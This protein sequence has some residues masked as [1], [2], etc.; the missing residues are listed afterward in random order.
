MNFFV[1]KCFFVSIAS[2]MVAMVPSVTMAQMQK[3]QVRT[4]ERPNKKSQGLGGVVITVREAPNS[5]LSSAEGSF[6]FSLPGKKEGDSYTVLGVQKTNYALVD[7]G[8]RG[9]KYGYSSKTPL[10][11]VMVSH[12]QLE[13]EKHRIEDNNSARALREY[14]KQKDELEALRREKRIS[15]E[16]YK[17]RQRRLGDDFEKLMSLIDKMAEMYALFDYKNISDLNRQIAEA[18]ENAEL[19]KAES[20]I[21]TKGDFDQREKQIKETMEMGRQ[22]IAMGE[23]TM[24]E[25]I[26]QMNDLAEDYY[27]QHTI[28]V[29]NYKFDEAATYLE[30]RAALDSTNAGWQLEVA[31]FVG[32]YLSDYER[33]EKCATKA[34]QTAL[35]KD[36]ANTKMVAYCLN[37]MGNN[38]CD[39]GKFDKALDYYWRSLE[40]RR[41]VFGEQSEETAK[42][43]SNMAVVYK[44]KDMLDSARVYYEKALQI[45]QASTDDDCGTIALSYIDMGQLE[46]TVGDAKKALEYYQMALPLISECKGE[47]SDAMAELCNALAAAN[48]DVDSLNAALGWYEKALEIE[49]K[50][51]GKDH[52]FVATIL[53]NMGVF[54]SKLRN[55]KKAYEL[56]SEALEIL[57]KTLGTSHPEIAHNYNN[58]ASALSNLGKIDE[59]LDYSEKALQLDMLFF[60]ENSSAVAMD[61]CNL[62]SIYLEKKQPEKAAQLQ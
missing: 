51:Y 5:V 16:I 49:K 10:E 56:H 39:A 44:H 15:E 3:G 36:G 13:E 14:N 43:Y 55:Y 50:L 28:L 22:Q 18:I 62:G 30:R 45:R 60:G 35:A 24:H 12:Q 9:R 32:T 47:N 29:S 61:Y 8:I 54:F 58:V 4:L 17:N 19:E 31:N 57:V 46:R 23:K 26:V 1:R 21:K 40:V 53:N 59:A 48:T 6:S 52:P 25:G 38:A 41:Y 42:C 27:R 2:M 11:I 20:L 33:A 7:K 34:L 37:D